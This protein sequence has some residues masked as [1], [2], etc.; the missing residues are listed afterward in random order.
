MNLGLGSNIHITAKVFRKGPKPRLIPNGMWSW[1]ARRRIPG[2]GKWIE[3]GEIA[4]TKQG[5]ALLV[6]H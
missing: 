1:M 5:N 6:N 4:S 3:L 2:T